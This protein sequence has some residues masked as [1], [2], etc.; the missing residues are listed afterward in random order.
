MV[1]ILNHLRMCFSRE[2]IDKNVV[3]FAK[4]NPEVTIYVRERNGKHPRIVANFSKCNFRL[5]SWEM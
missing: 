4:N 2:Y 1:M 3:E 5:S